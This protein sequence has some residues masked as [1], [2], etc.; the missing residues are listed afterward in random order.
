MIVAVGSLNP[1]KIESVRLAFSALWA[2]QDW[3]V[4]G[5]QV[6]SGVSAQPM[7]D[8]EARSGARTRARRAMQESDGDYAVGLEGGL[9]RVDRQC[10]WASCWQAANWAMPVTRSSSAVTPSTRRG[11][12]AS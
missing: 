1:V 5:Y 10:L 4:R 8:T 3:D 11:I 12:S 9:Q 2:A 6:S 7:T